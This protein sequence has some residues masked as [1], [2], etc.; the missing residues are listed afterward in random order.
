MC[1][2]FTIKSSQKELNE[3]FRATVHW[4]DEDISLVVAPHQRAPVVCRT[5]AGL[6]V[7]PMKFSLLPSW[8]KEPKVKF[9]THNARLET[10][11]EKA[12]WKRPFLSQHGILP[13]HQFIEPIYKG[14]HAGFM[15]AFQEKHHE[16]LAA[17]CVIDHW[18]NK[19]T[20]EVIDSF[21]IITG[22]PDPFVAEVG[23]DRQP[24]FLDEKGVSIWLDGQKHNASD[25]KKLLLNHRVK[26]VW[27]VE[28]F[29]PMKPGWQKRIPQ[30]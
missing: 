8:S 28:N 11:D 19:E 1:A 7:K 4:D 17:A 16:L 22:D 13:L 15:V 29:R 14:E 6:E 5:E 3:K 21:A 27:E 26:K 2:I 23:H 10:I 18:V 25:L 12:T 30:D 24:I 20:G 9:A